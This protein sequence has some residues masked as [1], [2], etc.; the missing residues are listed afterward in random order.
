MFE[1]AELLIPIKVKVSRVTPNYLKPL[2]WASGQSMEQAL[3]LH[4]VYERYNTG[5]CCHSPNVM[6]PHSMYCNAR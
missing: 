3:M 5:S 6:V 2:T 1:G 4:V